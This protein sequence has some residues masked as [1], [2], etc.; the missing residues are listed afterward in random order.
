MLDMVGVKYNERFRYISKKD[1][2]KLL[3]LADRLEGKLDKN[4]GSEEDEAD[5]EEEGGN[6]ETDHDCEKGNDDD[7]TFFDLVI[8]RANRRMDDAGL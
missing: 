1:C 8:A 7:N 4:K 6:E 3:K 5:G 2:A